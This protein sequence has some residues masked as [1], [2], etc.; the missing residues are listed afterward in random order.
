[1][2]WI[3]IGLVAAF[4]LGMTA[5]RLARADHKL[6]AVAGTSV[7]ALAALLGLGSRDWGIWWEFMTLFFGVLAVAGGA[8]W[9]GGVWAGLVL[10]RRRENAARP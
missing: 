9:S 10:R 8:A 7:I 6:I 1:M 2:S 3:P 4:V 5:G